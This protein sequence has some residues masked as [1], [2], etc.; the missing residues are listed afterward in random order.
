[1]D[2]IAGVSFINDSK[3]T[4]VGSTV[5]AL[6][7]LSSPTIL[8][9]GGVGKS[10]DFRPL[11]AAA[12][13]HAKAVVLIGRDATQIE[14]AINTGSAEATNIECL[15]ANDM[16][17]AVKLAYLRAVS[18]DVVL[19]SPACASFDMFNNYQHRG[20]EFK[21]SVAALKQLVQARNV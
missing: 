10:Q 13:H 3:A 2:T 15:Y 17:D 5:A 4:N 7:G 12:H 14:A 6:S 8:I 18:G 9:A 1:V 20:D 11:T 21:K 16:Q 19:L